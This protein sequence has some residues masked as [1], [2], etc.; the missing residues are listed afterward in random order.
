[1]S[2]TV[3]VTGAGRGIGRGIALRMAQDGFNVVVNDIDLGSALETAEEIKSLGRES[4]AIAADVSKEEDVYG[5]VGK[6]IDE[7]GKLDVMIANAGIANIKWTVEM[8]AAEWDQIFAVN[9]R[10][11]FLCDQAAAKQMI[12]K[13]RGKIINCSSIAGHAGFSLLAAYSA[14]KFA[15]RGFTQ[16]L[17]KEMG[18]YGITV[19]AYCPGIVGTDMWDLID[20]KMGPYL[21]LGKG[22]VLKE[23]SKLITMGRVQ[24]PADVANFVSYLASTDS[25]YMTGQSV[26]ID[27]GI[28]M[29]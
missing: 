4:M 16:A 25:D 17:A 7:F 14:T 24:T 29:N 13:K 27:G 23:Y 22:E 5:M 21:K 26:I 28:V 19:N 2:R 1:M 20:E 8:S 6:V 3:I 10:G 9:C 15:V 18:P 11:T 12:K